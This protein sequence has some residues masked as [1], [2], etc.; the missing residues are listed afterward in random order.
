MKAQKRI[1]LLVAMLLAVYE[2]AAAPGD[3]SG[4]SD[5]SDSS[6]SSDISPI[7]KNE[8]DSG[9]P[10]SIPVQPQSDFFDLYTV[11]IQHRDALYELLRGGSERQAIICLNALKERALSDSEWLSLLVSICRVSPY[12]D[13]AAAELCVAG[14]E[15]GNGS[16]RAVAVEN[17]L[18]GAG[19]RTRS[20]FHAQIRKAIGPKPRTDNERYLAARCGMS[21]EDLVTSTE[22]GGVDNLLLRALC[23]D[24]NAEEEMIEAFSSA[25][26][27]D[28]KLK[29]VRPLALVGSEAC[30]A[31]LIK[32]LND[33]RIGF[34]AGDF[35]TPEQL[36]ELWGRTIRTPIVL[37]LGLVYEDE[38]LFNKD[39]LLN[40]RYGERLNEW[41]VENFGHLAVTFTTNI[42]F[43]ARYAGNA[44]WDCGCDT[45]DVCGST[46]SMDETM[47][48]VLSRP[49][50][51]DTSVPAVGTIWTAEVGSG[52]C[53]E[54]MPIQ[55]GSFFMGSYDT[56][57]INEMPKHEVIISQPF[58]LSRTEV[59]I[60]QYH[61]VMGGADFA[62]G[63][64]Q[65]P[66][67][68]INRSDAEEF[69]R[70]LTV[71][72]HESGRLS[73]HYE[74]ALPSEAQWEYACRAGSTADTV[75]ELAA[76]AWCNFRSAKFDLKAETR[77]VGQKQA[78]RW[79]LYDMLGN[80]MEWCADC[81]T[82]S[83]QDRAH[84]EM[85]Y[86]RIRESPC[87]MVA[88]G[89]SVCHPAR[90]VRPSWRDHIHHDWPGSRITGFRPLLRI[91]HGK[92]SAEEGSGR[93]VRKRVTH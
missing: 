27:Y 61:A 24:D 37:A 46:H 47:I 6:M 9:H 21:W 26:T 63:K 87:S 85:P 35:F 12:N 25:S 93:G 71:K 31:A 81:Y 3:D 59:T 50:Q 33:P 56:G 40:N 20:L 75:P 57:I 68:S 13:A 83:Y 58:W 55:P 54:F 7:S 90:V 28:D 74:Y 22:T 11:A 69:C 41:A 65:Y 23:G 91:K 51:T 77:P 73:P 16:I 64:G 60:E 39:Q 19:P 29:W 76:E 4:K 67:H 30:A 44:E 53:M 15:S 79:G 62:Q 78:N 66:A 89:G 1:F 45:N 10:I 48:S 34:T 52:I 86:G 2:V 17:L 42:W 70:R 18:W 49:R 43:E 82:L 84:T 80:V 72:G 8:D 92:P 36:N 5:R 14:I 32:G 88:R 38:E